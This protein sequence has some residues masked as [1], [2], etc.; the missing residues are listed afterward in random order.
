MYLACTH[1]P[2]LKTHTPSLLV[3]IPA[4]SEGLSLPLRAACSSLATMPPLQTSLLPLSL[5]SLIW[6]A[7]VVPVGSSGFPD[8]AQ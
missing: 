2:P 4:T 3:L 1:P 8:K 5:L 7:W 6:A